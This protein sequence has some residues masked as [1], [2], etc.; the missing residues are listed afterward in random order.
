[1]PWGTVTRAGGVSAGDVVLTGALW[2]AEARAP[3]AVAR[4]HGP[5]SLP[6]RANVGEGH[7]AG[8]SA[9]ASAV[10]AGSGATPTSGV[11]R[12]SPTAW[13]ES[14]PRPNRTSGRSQQAL[15]TIGLTGFGAGCRG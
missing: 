5:A 4:D 2:L 15:S 10:Q 1:M 3:R 8:E 9:K 11:R 6:A 7:P 12:R 14:A 13:A